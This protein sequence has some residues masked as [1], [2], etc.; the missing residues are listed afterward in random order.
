ML[1]WHYWLT[2]TDNNIAYHQTTLVSTEDSPA[3][4]QTT[5]SK[6]STLCHKTTLGSTEDSTVIINKKILLSTEDST[7]NNIAIYWR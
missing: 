6:D 1:A 2:F 5:S 4:N 7:A 3:C